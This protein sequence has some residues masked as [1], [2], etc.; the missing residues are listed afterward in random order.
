MCGDDAATQLTSSRTAEV[1]GKAH[2]VRAAVDAGPV[3][4]AWVAARAG[5]ERNH[6]RF[7]DAGA[8]QERDHVGLVAV[9]A[10][11]ERDNV[12]RACAAGGAAG[13]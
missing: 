12:F 9:G 6:V 3:R 1:S 4:A 8:G 10:G 5:A 7:G 13:A 2:V 11:A